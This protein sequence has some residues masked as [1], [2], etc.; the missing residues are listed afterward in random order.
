MPEGMRFVPN[1]E[2]LSYE[3]M[4]RIAKVLIAEGVNKIRITGGEPFLRKDLM[5]LLRSLAEM[6]GLDKIALTTNATLTAQYLDQ[7]LSLGIRSFNVSLDSLDADRFFKITRRNV[8]QEVKSC[9]EEMMQ[10]DLDLKLNCVVMRGKNIDDIIPFV[11]MTRKNKIEVRFIEEMPFNGHQSTPDL[12]WDYKKILSHISSEYSEIEKLEDPLYSTSLNYKVK[13]FQGGFGVI[14]AYTRNFCGSCN[15]IRIT[16]QGMFKSCLYDDGVFNIKNF[17]R[18][19][20]TDAQI[21]D[22]VREALAMKSID[23]YEAERLRSESASESMS[24]IG[25]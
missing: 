23:G 18:A 2:L 1:K 22:L 16:A 25:G 19:G 14:P 8:F 20:A 17:M 13:G 7:L 3:E 12:E 9:I 4:L 24:T 5:F 15:R 11:E 10:N 21:L 6:D